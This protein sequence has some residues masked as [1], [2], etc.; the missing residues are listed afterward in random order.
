MIRIDPTGHGV[1]YTPFAHDALPSAFAPE[2]GTCTEKMSS[3]ERISDSCT[4]DR[5]RILLTCNI[6]TIITGILTSRDLGFA[7]DR[8]RQMQP[9]N[10]CSRIRIT[11]PTVTHCC[12]PE[13]EDCGRYRSD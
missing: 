7:C 12:M 8:K 2:P 10:P 11:E 6:D 5:R 4:R 13:V 3:S 9:A 1:L